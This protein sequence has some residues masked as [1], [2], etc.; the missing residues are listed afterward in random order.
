MLPGDEQDFYIEGPACYGHAGKEIVCR[1][2]LE[3]FKATLGVLQVRKS[4]QA[5]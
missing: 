4:Q 1:F 3:A 5:D 2:R